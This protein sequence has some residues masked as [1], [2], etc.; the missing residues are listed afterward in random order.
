[1]HSLN[2]GR[3]DADMVKFEEAI[4]DAVVAKLGAD[5]TDS[6]AG[7]GQ[8]GVQVPNLHD[9]GMGTEVLQR[10]KPTLTSMQWCMVPANHECTAFKVG[11]RQ[12]QDQ[13]STRS[14]SA[15]AQPISRG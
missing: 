10:R 13:T 14:T 12:I 9:E 7:Q 2:H 1:M 8:M 5:V 6:D 4:V 11:G 15:L 3:T